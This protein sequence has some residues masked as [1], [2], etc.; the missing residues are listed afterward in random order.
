MNGCKRCLGCSRRLN[1]C[2]VP[3]LRKVF[4]NTSL[5]SVLC[6]RVKLIVSYLSSTRKMLKFELELI[7]LRVE[8]DY[9][10]T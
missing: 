6:K 5:N 8:F 10:N 3:V 4:E 7:E 9:Y 1:A 2:L